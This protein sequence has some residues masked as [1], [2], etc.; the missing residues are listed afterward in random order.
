MLVGTWVSANRVGQFAGPSGGTA[1]AQSIGYRESYFVGAAVMGVVAMT[2]MPLRR[3]GR[4]I[5][6]RGGQ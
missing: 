2:W 3:L 6:Q 1:V 5:S 4:S